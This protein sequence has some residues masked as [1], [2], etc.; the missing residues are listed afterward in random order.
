MSEAGKEIKK[1]DKNVILRNVLRVVLIL[2][3]VA[4]IIVGIFNHEVKVVLT[5]AVN[6][7]LECI[8]IG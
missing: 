3:F 6:I 4:C 2:F 5:K 7:C 8:G 1:T